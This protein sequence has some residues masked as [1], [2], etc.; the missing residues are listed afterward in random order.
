MTFCLRRFHLLSFRGL[1]IDFRDGVKQLDNIRSST[2]RRR[3][4][5]NKRKDTAGL[6]G[7]KR[8][9]LY[10]TGEPS[11]QTL[12]TSGLTI[13]PAKKWKV[14]A[15]KFDTK[16][17]PYQNTRAMTKKT[18][19]CDMPYNAL[20]QIAVRFDVL[21]GTSRLS[22]YNLQQSSSLVNE[23]TVRIAPAASQAS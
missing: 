13:R 22:L 8:R 1:C 21:S 9:T 3:Y 12:Y 16:M 23:A 6:D 4:I 18:S 19:A 10:K 5:R 14:E 17:A 2:F 7:A 15:S 11:S 20:L